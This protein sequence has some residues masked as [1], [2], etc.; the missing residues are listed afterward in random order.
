M[1]GNELSNLDQE[2]SDYQFPLG[3]DF[4]GFI[5]ALSAMS[6]AMNFQV[7]LFPIHSNQEDK[8]LKG[9]M[10]SIS[11]SMLLVQSIYTIISLCGLFLYGK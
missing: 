1:R 4:K 7:N 10:R 5:L 11:I 3:N 9:S 6:T 8:S 2:Y